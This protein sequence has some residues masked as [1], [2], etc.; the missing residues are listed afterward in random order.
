[1]KKYQIWERTYEDS[2]CGGML[3]P[4]SEIEKMY[5]M[6]TCY[7]TEVP[8]SFLSKLNDAL[9]S[10]PEVEVDSEISIKDFLDSQGIECKPEDITHQSGWIPNRNRLYYDVDNREFFTLDEYDLVP[11]YQYWNG[12]NWIFVECGED[13]TVTEVTVEDETCNN[14]DTW[15]G[16]NWNTGSNGL[17]QDVFRVL[18]LDG[19]TVKDTFLLR[20]WSQ[21]QGDHDMGQ[22]MTAAELEAHIVKLSSG[23]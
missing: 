18:E 13:I 10:N 15:D 4:A 8:A 6:Q 21:W 20:H 1:M 12:S 14:L 23:D 9:N 7:S 19:E 22:V 17:H 11:V 5:Y 16:N 2:E 3:I